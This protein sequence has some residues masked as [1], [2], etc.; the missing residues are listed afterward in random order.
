VEEQKDILKRVYLVYILCCVFAVA[1]L[2]R[3][4]YL[5]T[6]QG[7]HWKAEAKK[8]MDKEQEIEAV[9][10]NIFAYDGSLLATS[11]PYYEVAID[12]LANIRIDD[13]EFEDSARALANGL[14]RV[15]KEHTSSEY[16]STLM[17]ARR[18]GSRYEQL[19][20]D[21]SYKEL[22]ELKTLPLFRAGPFKGGFIYVQSNHRELPFR[23]LA[24]RTIG[25]VGDSG[26]VKVGLEGAF[27]SVLTGTRGK[28]LMQKI[29]G[30]VWKPL[31]SKNEI[32]P[33]QGRDIVTTIDINI[34]DVAE[35]ALKETLI[36]HNA[37][38]G[39]VVL[40]EVKSGEIRAIANLTRKDSGV[41]VEDYNYAIGDAREPGSTF[42]LASLLVAIDDGLVNL[43]DKVNLEGG[44]HQFFNR[45]MH[46]SHAP[47]ENI[48]TVEQAFWA[49]SNVGISKVINTTYAKS[50]KKF[51]DGLQE[52]R[53]GSPLGIEIPGEG[54]SHIRTAGEKGWS[55]VSLPWISIGYESTITPLQTLTLYNAVANNGVMVKPMFVKEIRDKGK[56]VTAFPTVVLNP[57][58]AKPE[59]IAKARSLLEGVVKNGTGRSLASSIYTIA[60]KTGTAQIANGADYGKATG[61]VTYQASFVGYFPANDPKYSLIVVVNAPSGDVYYGGDVAGPIFKQIANRVFATE[62]DIHKPVNNLVNPLTQ[63]PVVKNGMGIPTMIALRGLYVNVKADTGFNEDG[64]VTIRPDNKGVRVANKNHDQQLSRGI[65][66]DLSGM[67]APDVLFL[68]ENRGYRVR[69]KGSGAVKRQ[70]VPAGQLINKNTEI[71]VELSL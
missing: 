7:E 48:V 57:A 53:F 70:S 42:K 12:P 11:L 62:M 5:Q 47:K 64:Y 14:A 37:K 44:Q 27:D 56:T 13:R 59:T 21:V 63:I 31:N 65:M 41:Y 25:Y 24:A 6:V 32:D 40:M 19:A 9:R 38:Y 66:P 61:T 22:L 8:F 2:G 28:R 39:C 29:A 55:G 35:N 16:F 4:F 49:S 71:L 45:V 30:G 23:M 51:T 36:Q 1:I 17:K 58:I 20:R 67:A 15:L 69:L 60:G 52:L 68:L 50:P 33:L 10:G 34:Q 3:V 43:S 18:K 46:D 26:R 54:Y